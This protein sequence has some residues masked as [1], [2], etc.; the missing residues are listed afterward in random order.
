M[1]CH[2]YHAA[3]DLMNT[4]QHFSWGILFLAYQRVPLNN[5]TSLD[6][7]PVVARYVKLDPRVPVT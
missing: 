3:K 4:F 5:L 7:C 6:I 2:G 1:S